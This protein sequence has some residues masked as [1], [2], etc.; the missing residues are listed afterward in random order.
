MRDPSKAESHKIVKSTQIRKDITP[1]KKKK[2]GWPSY[3]SSDQI[4]FK[5]LLKI[6]RIL[7]KNKRFNLQEGNDD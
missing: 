7:K 1:S 2:K 6:K 5:V 3:I 4:N